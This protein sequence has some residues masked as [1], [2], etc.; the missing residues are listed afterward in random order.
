MDGPALRVYHSVMTSASESSRRYLAIHTGR[1]YTL[2]IVDTRANQ[3]LVYADPVARRKFNAISAVT[4]EGTGERSI[5]RAANDC[6]GQSF[7]TL[8]AL[9]AS[10]DDGVAVERAREFDC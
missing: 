6:L 1:T 2:V 5:R 9:N 10:V 3:C 7:A 4:V 8:K